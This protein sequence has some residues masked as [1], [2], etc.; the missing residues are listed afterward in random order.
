M[1]LVTACSNVGPRSLRYGRGTYNTAVQQTNSEQLLLNLV[2]LR[3]RDPPLF[4]EV[5][6]ISSSMSVEVGGTLGGSVFSGRTAS[7]SPATG[8]TYIDRP[9]IT[10]SPLQG[11]RFGTQFLS[12]VALS[13]ILLLYHAGWA[14]DR[15]FK[16]FV[17]K[18]GPLQNAPRASGPTPVVAPQFEQYFA[19][20]DLLRSLWADGL[21]D[22]AYTPSVAGDALT[23]TIGQ[24][25]DAGPRVARLCQ[26]LGLQRATSTIILT[27]TPR[28]DEP[29]AV[30]LV[31]RSLLG[32]MYYVSHGVEVPPVDYEIGRVPTTRDAAGEKFEWS[33]M[34]G[35]LLR[36]HHSAREP[37]G[38]YVAVFYRGLWFYIDDADLDSKA[39]F[40]FLIEALE[41]QSGEIKAGNVPVLT[42]PIAAQ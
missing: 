25:P 37:S 23:L 24:H 33:R 15:I 16:V 21:I 9:T 11:T 6:S 10:Y 29:N 14:I 17:Q 40:S 30:R 42:L 34:L 18:L 20:T 2:R 28:R 36:I 4:L 27:D 12:P 8:V 35:N 39:T 5:T 41:L 7:V 3:Y 13:D 22:L 19:A 31:P 1:A 26:L 32:G 38:A